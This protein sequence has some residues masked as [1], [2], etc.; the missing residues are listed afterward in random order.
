MRQARELLTAQGVET[1]S[2]PQR[3]SDPSTP[4]PRL[5]STV[6]TNGATEVDP[7]SITALRVTFDRDMAGGFS[8][9]G[10][11]PLF[12]PTNGSPK[13]LDTRTCELPV[14]LEAGKLYRVGI[15]SKSHRNF[16][17]VSGV[18]ARPTVIAFT[19]KGAGEELAEQLK[20][21]HVVTMEP[22]NGAVN[23]SPTLDKLRVTFDRPMG[24]G[25]SWTGGGENYPEA[26]GPPSW[27]EDR[28]TCVLPVRLKPNW[29]Y[30]LGLNSPSHINFQSIGGIPLEPVEWTFTTTP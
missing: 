21:P 15:N 26:T 7:A 17:S 20:P 9:T 19:T 1:P 12:P 11:P 6:P 5:V 24:G 4:P 29:S 23:V 10:G 25:F 13:W 2:V 28:M 27:S 22:G 30:R 16:K 14:A 8:W 3:D 18:P